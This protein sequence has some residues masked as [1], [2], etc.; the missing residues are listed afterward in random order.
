MPPTPS[1][2]TA[3]Q[4]LLIWIG[5]PIVCATL[6]RH[7]V[8]FAARASAR[9]GSSAKVSVVGHLCV[10]HTF[11]WNNHT[12]LRV[13]S[14][15]FDGAAR[16]CHHSATQRRMYSRSTSRASITLGGSAGW[17]AGR[18][19]TSFGCRRSVSVRPWPGCMATGAG[20]R[21]AP[22]RMAVSPGPGQLHGCG[23]SRGAGGPW[24]AQNHSM[25][26][27]T[28]GAQHGRVWV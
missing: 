5:R 9:S 22:N 8:P 21:S 18:C 11:N 17:P 28:F 25:R 12:T 13:A 16:A 14:A 6:A 26:A 2:Y 24:G 15:L 4:P 19:A 20:L 3:C 1:R 27:P 7:W 10:L 23:A